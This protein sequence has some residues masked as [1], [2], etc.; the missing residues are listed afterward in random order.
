MLCVTFFCRYH[1][2]KLVFASSISRLLIIIFYRALQ[3][4]GHSNI[5]QTWGLIVLLV[6]KMAGISDNTPI[7]TID[8]ESGL[9]KNQKVLAEIVEM[10]STANLIHSTGVFNMQHLN[11]AG[12]H[13]NPDNAMQLGNKLA[14]LAGDI[15]MGY[16]AHQMGKIR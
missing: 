11:A 1:G 10:N 7:D 8:S 2:T 14:L 5:F 3:L 13:L 4:D 6:S 15:L 12:I 9:L 16:T